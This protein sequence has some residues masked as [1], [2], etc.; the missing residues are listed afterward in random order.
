MCVLALAWRANPAWHLVAIANRDERHARASLALDRWIDEPSILAGRDKVSSGTWMGVTSTGRLCAITN[1]GGREYS[2]G[3]PSRGKL[4][5]G[6]LARAGRYADP[7]T[8]DL[9]LFN[10]FN[11][12]IVADGEAWIWTNVA[13]PTKRRLD[14]GIYGISN[15]PWPEQWAKTNRLEEGLGEWIASKRPT[16]ALLDLLG[17]TCGFDPLPNSDRSGAPIFIND[18]VYGTRC[19]TVVTVTA[20]G[21]GLIVERRFDSLGS[22]SGERTFSFEWPMPAQSLQTSC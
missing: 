6:I 1:I 4:V 11:L 17:S 8:A 10:P 3:A 14:S 13:A 2:Q 9:A 12:A 19:S 22:V 20:S 18:S 16:S 21:I 15:G 7:T 5:A